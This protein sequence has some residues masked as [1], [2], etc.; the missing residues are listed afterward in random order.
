MAITDIATSLATTGIPWRTC[1]TCHA[2][3]GMSDEDAAVLRR[4]LA[5]R[6]IKFKDLAL[7]LADAARGLR[8]LGIKKLLH[9][10]TYNCRPIRGTQQLSRHGHA[11]AIGGA[12]AN[13]RSSFRWRSSS[14]SCSG[15][16]I[17]P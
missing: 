2:L 16:S 11:N 9:M 5:D 12:G 6:S 17:R 14:S 7:A 15:S 13:G 10:G 4:L 3:A 8:Q 1:G